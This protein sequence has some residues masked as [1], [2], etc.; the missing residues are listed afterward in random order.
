MN[1]ALPDIRETRVE[2]QIAL[3]HEHSVNIHRRIQALYLIKTHQVKT[4]KA[5]ASVIGV[6]RKTIGTWLTRY[7]REGF[8]A[9]CTMHTHPNR[10]RVIAGFVLNELEQ[11]LERPQGF[12]GYGAICQWLKER[13][14]LTFP[15]K[16]VY[17][18]VRS[19]L[20]AKLKVPRQSNIQK[21]PAAQEA[22]ITTEF[23][24]Q[25]KTIAAQAEPPR[26]IRVF[27]QDEARFGLMTPM[28]RVVTAKGVKPIGSYQHRFDNYYLYGAVEPLTGMDCYLELPNLD[29]ACFQ[30]FL[31]EFSS[32]F[33]DSFNLL[34]LDRGTFHRAH[35]LVIPENVRLIFQPAH[36]PELNPIERLWG[37]LRQRLGSEIFETLEHLKQRI[38]QLLRELS[39]GR[40]QSLTGFPYFLKAVNETF[41]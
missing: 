30:V 25:L 36:S 17:K 21:D 40:V 28:T 13:F 15:Y 34:L 26:P 8:Q 19:D 20:Q 27:T 7:E 9:L 31:N 5:L 14:G 24:H 3:H 37:Y 6:G 10:L 38:V 1:K 33:A 4:R 32:T 35:A 11:Q 2:L 16:T 41:Q 22:F 23:A 12:S 39:R 18:T 29:T